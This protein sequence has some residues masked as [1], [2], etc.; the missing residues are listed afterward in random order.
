[1]R[2]EVLDL[3]H[4]TMLGGLEPTPG[5]HAVAVARDLGRGF[6]SCGRESSVMVFSLDSLKEIARVPVQGRNPDAILYEPA[7]KRVLT[8]NGGTANV[9]V[10]DAATGQV[11][12][13]VDLG[14]KPELPVAD[15]NGRVFVNI[16]D[17]S[18][19]LEFDPA[20]MKVLRRWSIAPGEEPSG[21]AIDR[22]HRRLFSVCGNHLMV[23]SDADKGTV[24]GTA[25]IGGGVDG[26]VF[27]TKRAL[28]ISSNGEGTVTVVHEDSPSRFSV[29][30]TDSTERGARTIALDE[31]TGAVFLP[32]ASF[33]ET[34]APTPERPRPRPAIVPGTF[35][36]L[37]LR[38]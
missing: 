38:P 25:P 37:V 33:G 36:I 27:D 32:T 3:D 7:S 8:F 17:K 21:L 19:V 34:P 35:R 9:T 1:M 5:A 18:E 16:E 24:V 4:G 12:G 23:I 15:G 30:E 28:A 14:G 11:L 26:V 10:L 20:A 31:K 13:L 2:I 6:V 29:V 22:G